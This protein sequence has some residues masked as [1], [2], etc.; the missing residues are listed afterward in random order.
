MAT[1]RGS[2][3][4]RLHAEAFGVGDRQAEEGDVAR[5]AVEA[6]GGV[7]PVALEHFD[8]HVWS[9]RGEA[10]DD[11]GGVLLGGVGDEANGELG[12]SGAGGGPHASL[13]A[14]YAVQA[15]ALARATAAG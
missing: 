6:G 14:Y 11:G 15:A 1:R 3:E 12:E 5:A 13:S 10:A 4:K 9:Q 7:F 8:A 2:L